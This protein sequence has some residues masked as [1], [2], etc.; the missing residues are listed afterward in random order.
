MKIPKDPAP[1]AALKKT[2]GAILGAALAAG[3]LL[4]ASPAANG[5]STFLLRRGGEIVYGR[6]FD[7]FFGGGLVM[8]N[9]RGIAKTA[10]LPNATNPARWVSRYGSVTFNQVS[11]EYPYGG[12]NEAGLVVENMWLPASAFPVPDAR[13]PIPELQW[14][15]F[16]LDN[17]ATVAEVIATDDS[18]RIASTGSP[19]HFF[20]ADRTG[21]AAAI[22][23]VGGRMVVHRGADL[24]VPALTND[25]YDESMKYLRL[26]RGFGG[27][28]RIVGTWESLDRFTV[29]ASMLADRG[30]VPRGREV[31]R[32]FAI[33]DAVSQG[34]GT[35]WSVVYEIGRGRLFF[36]TVGNGDIRI[37]NLRKIDFD[38][39]SPSRVFDIEAPAKGDITRR[40]EPYSTELNLSMVKRTFEGFHEHDFM[41]SVTEPMQEYL[42]RYPEMLP[43]A[44]G[45]RSK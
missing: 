12:M 33:L 17:C 27:T 40:F 41:Q 29:I 31:R 1:M 7:F 32:A 22:E 28:K 45:R 39:A 9:Q 23:F 21:D 20:V 25:T 30:A 15:Q 5:C 4:I 34:G 38:C 24:P 16:Q 35:V 2:A 6:N 8:T 3:L 36:K 18:I 44:G 26:H 37:V 43:C 14:I 42:A 10:L 11:K 13:A 19:I